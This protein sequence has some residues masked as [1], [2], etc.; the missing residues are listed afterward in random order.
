MKIYFSIVSHGH[1]NLVMHLGFLA[2][3]AEYDSV[4]VIVKSNKPSSNGVFNEYCHANRIVFLDDNYGLGFGA[5]NNLVF[6]YCLDI[7]M[8]VEHD[9]FC[10]INPDVVIDETNLQRLLEFVK[11]NS[12]DALSINLYRD[13][14]MSV[15]DNS[16]RTFPSACDFFSSFLFKVNGTIIDKS[17]I[18]HP[19]VIDWAAGSFILFRSTVYFYLSG[20]DE[21]FFM[22]CE[23]ID[24]CYRL[25]KLKYSLTFL[26]FVK[27]I[28]LAEHANRNILSKHFYWHLKSVCRYLFLR[29]LQRG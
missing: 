18:T 11:S 12:F 6:R 7:G 10:V 24:I 25:R 17:V 1:E 29:A 13:S 9:L 19:T 3:L 14:S 8:D 26:P 2:K 16:I 27:G 22:Y 15:Y 20:F 4:V 23:D 28:H 21:K 5:N